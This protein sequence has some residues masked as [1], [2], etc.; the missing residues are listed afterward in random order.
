MMRFR[1]RMPQLTRNAADPAAAANA[2][3][4]APHP[5][6]LGEAPRRRTRNPLALMLLPGLHPAG[7]RGSNNPDHRAAVV[8]API[9]LVRRKRKSTPMP[10][11]IPVPTDGGATP[12][13]GKPAPPSGRYHPRKRR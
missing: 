3:P 10:V 7:Q 12:A 6:R 13:D 9:N 4:A 11:R 8:P 2:L 5:K 1:C